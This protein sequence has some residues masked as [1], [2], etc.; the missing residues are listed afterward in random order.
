VLG[1]AAVLG[2]AVLGRAVLGRAVLG[3]AV[4]GRAVRTSMPMRRLLRRRSRAP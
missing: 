3:R 4:L 2:R 1:R